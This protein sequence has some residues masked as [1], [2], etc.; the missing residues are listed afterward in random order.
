MNVIYQANPLALDTLGGIQKY[1]KSVKYRLNKYV[2]VEDVEDRK[3]AYNA[4]TKAFVDIS[5]EEW[6]TFL[7]D[8]PWTDYIDFLYGTYFKVPEDFDEMNCV[9]LIREQSD[10]INAKR[11]NITEPFIFTILPTTS[12]NARCFYCY[13]QGRTKKFMSQETAEKAVQYMKD[14]YLLRNSKNKKDIVELRWFGGEPTFNSKII[15]YICR[16]LGEEKIPYSSD[17]ISNAYLL[18]EDMVKTA[19]ELWHLKSIQVTLDGTEEVYNKAKNFIYKEEEKGSPYKIV[20][21]NIHYLLEANISV[22]IRMN[23]D[24]YNAEDM[25]SLIDNLYAEFGNARGFS[26]YAYPLFDG[27]GINRTEE[28]EKTVYEKLYIID[29]KLEEYHYKQ[30]T[31]L[32]MDYRSRHCMVDSGQE[33]LISPEGD[34]GLCEHYTED[35]FFGHLDN[36]DEI[37]WNVIMSFRKRMPLLDI[38]KDCPFYANC[39]RID[40]CPDLRICDKYMK[41]WRIH[42]IKHGMREAYRKYINQSNSCGCVDN[43][44]IDD[45]R[46]DITSLWDMVTSLRSRVE[47]LEK[48]ALENNEPIKDNTY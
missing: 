34:L 37:D 31:P 23:L 20:T 11:D 25:L 39:I 12:C 32:P 7:N 3:L 10:E 26:V 18:N 13:E 30:D 45:M 6:E 44:L 43:K 5:N 9:D 33:V 1:Q 42:Q 4:M 41:Q 46:T 35:N 21:Q 38:C 40:K 17:M 24:Q 27:Y 14:K 28:D 48:Q 2:V 47:V 19:K 29:K 22:S 15:D 8:G 16:R 36:P